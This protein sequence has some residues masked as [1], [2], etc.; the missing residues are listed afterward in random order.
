MGALTPGAAVTLRGFHVGE[1]T[2]VALHY[3]P[4]SGKLATPVTIALHPDRIAGAAK[5]GSL[6][7][8]LQRLVG[9]GLRARLAQDPPVIGGRTIALDFVKNAPAA[10]LVTG[11][12]YPEIPS[13]ASGDL[14]GLANTAG[15][16]LGKIDAL[17]LAEISRSVR[18]SADHLDALTASPELKQSLDHLRAALANL[19]AV[20]RDV[21]GRAPPLI[22]S[23][24]KT[25]DAAQSTIGAMDTVM[26]GGLGEQDSN[27]PHALRELASAARSIRALA[28][29]LEQHPEALIEGK[30][31]NSQ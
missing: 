3:D 12:A 13:A 10:S 30:S 21:R 22:A 7:A 2:E 29:Y 19:D 14:G 8:T 15:D 1:V 23:L 28:G 6:D 20:S 24:Q 31:G 16:I 18:E 5:D 11:G 25:A 9:E 27:L 4:A 17:P 26:G